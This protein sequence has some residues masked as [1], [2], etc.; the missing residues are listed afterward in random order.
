[1]RITYSAKSTSTTQMSRLTGVGTR[2]LLACSRSSCSGSSVLPTSRLHREDSKRVIPCE[3]IQLR[4]ELDDH[5]LISLDRMAQLTA[6]DRLDTLRIRR[7]RTRVLSGVLSKPLRWRLSHDSPS[8]LGFS[9]FRQTARRPQ[10]PLACAS[11]FGAYCGGERSSRRIE[12]RLCD[13]VAFRVIG[14][15]QAPDHATLARFR[16]RHQDAIANVPKAGCEAI[17]TLRFARPEA[18]ARTEGGAMKVLIK[19]FAVDMEVKSKGIEF[20]VKSPDGASHLGDCYVTKTSIIWCKGRTPKANGVKISWE[21]LTAVLASDV[22]KR[23]AVGAARN[24]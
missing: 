7:L 12:Q 24:A 6:A 1:M 3:R 15:N 18:S 22:T 19:E 20:E 13:D 11:V 21:E 5:D 17:E 16:R 9:L 14:A 2:R 8:G 10:N 23:A 4:T